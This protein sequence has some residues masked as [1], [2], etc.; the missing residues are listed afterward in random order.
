M[1]TPNG[2][3]SKV[4]EGVVV[5]LV[6]PPIDPP[7]VAP[8]FADQ[9]ASFMGQ[10]TKAQR[11]VDAEL[12]ATR[13]AAEAAP[14]HGAVLELSQ[15]RESTT[16]PRKRWGDLSDLVGSIRVSGILL[17]LIVRKIPGTEVFEIVCGARRFRAGKL[18]GLEVFPVEVREL[19]DEHV[20]EFQIVENIQRVDLHPME[21]AEGYSELI[22]LGYSVPTLALRVSKSTGWVRN[23]LQLLKLSPEGR[24][25]FFE[26]SIDI[27]VAYVLARRP[28]ANQAKA[29]VAIARFEKTRDKITHLQNDFERNL[30]GSPFDLKDTT[31]PRIGVRPDEF[32]DDFGD[33]A[34]CP[35][36]SNNAPVE[37]FGDYEKIDRAGICSNTACFAGKCAAIVDRK[38]ERAKEAG[39]AVLSLGQAKKFLAFGTSVGGSPYVK[40]SDSIA[41]DPKRRTWDQ[42]FHE[43]EADELPKVTFAPDDQHPGATVKLFDRKEAIAA[44]VSLGIKG[45]KRQAPATAKQAEALKAKRKA[46]DDKARV[47]AETVEQALPQLTD[48]W[49][50]AIALPE[51]RAAAVAATDGV[52]IEQLASIARALEVPA[53]STVEKWI[54]KTATIRHLIAFTT[55]ALLFPR[56]LNGGDELDPELKVCA[57]SSGVDLAEIGRAQLSAAK[58]APVLPGDKV[59]KP[60]KV[61]KAVS[62]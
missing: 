15:L 58:A 33:C 1:E 31:L 47:I 43:L 8:S 34:S 42:A 45:A 17:P 12:E 62:K 38:L 2:T 54:E 21:E 50:K 13:I 7:V 39:S 6:K 32:G 55:A 4:I 3:G 20:R 52:S 24:G 35:M 41:D 9:V 27:S 23:R 53:N 44:A 25:A 40:A 19:S 36:N 56:W 16:N 59:I 30:K 22:D 14:R 5:P 51:L 37:L 60:T 18:A 10:G 26:G 28:H 11:A 49:V 61:K 57:R 29:L 46:S 48:R